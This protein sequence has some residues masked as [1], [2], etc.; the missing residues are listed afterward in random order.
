MALNDPHLLVFTLWIS[1]SPRVGAGPDDS[2][3]TGEYGKNDVKSL[4]S[5]GSKSL[6]SSC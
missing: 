3:P 4:S 5:L 2:L 6:I 1:T